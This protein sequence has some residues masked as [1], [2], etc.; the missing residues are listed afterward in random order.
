MA[1]TMS[2]RETYLS[3][4]PSISTLEEDNEEFGEFVGVASEEDSESGEEGVAC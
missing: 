3:N 2:V 1:M 4:V